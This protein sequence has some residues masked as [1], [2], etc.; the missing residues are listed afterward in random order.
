MVE[1][2]HDSQLFLKD[3]LFHNDLFQ[4]GAHVR[5]R[6]VGGWWVE[7]L[8]SRGSRWLRS[9]WLGEMG[10]LLF[11]SQVSLIFGNKILEELDGLLDFAISWNLEMKW[12]YSF[13]FFGLNSMIFNGISVNID[14]VKH[15]ILGWDAF[16]CTFLC[17]QVLGS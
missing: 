12:C 10:N 13:D 5:L 7:D 6:A 9:G 11:L 17:K 2:L 8:V 15:L 16:V 3:E 1:Q 4:G 14:L